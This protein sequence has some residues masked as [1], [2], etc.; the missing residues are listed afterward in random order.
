M[1]LSSTALENVKIVKTKLTSN[2]YL[3]TFNW[4]CP[5]ANTEELCD[6]EG[7][8]GQHLLHLMPP[9]CPLA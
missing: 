1:N 7:A 2:L 4:S 3:I 5:E 9:V 8:G 6:V